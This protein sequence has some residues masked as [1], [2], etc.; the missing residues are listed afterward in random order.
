MPGSMGVSV[1]AKAATISAMGMIE[2]NDSES[3]DL[4]RFSNASSPF[5]TIVGNIPAFYIIT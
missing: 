3:L 4:I 5:K 1:T 2:V